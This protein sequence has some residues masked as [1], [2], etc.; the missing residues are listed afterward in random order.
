MKTGL[1]RKFV[2][3]FFLLITTLLIS[4]PAYTEDK[5][6]PSVY[7]R[8][9]VRFG[10]DDRTLFIMDF[11][12]PIWRGDKSVVFFNPK[13][14]ADDHDGIETNLGL[15]YRRLLFDDRVILGG[16][17]F[18]DNRLTGWGTRWEQIGLG[19]EAMA[20]F[21]EYVALTGRVN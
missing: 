10:S 12:V 1:S 7:F 13:F 18:Y 4:A 6:S 21:N 5:T 9:G 11:L 8:P 20:E 15:G 19:V 3:A 14:T 16:N 17:V 2:I